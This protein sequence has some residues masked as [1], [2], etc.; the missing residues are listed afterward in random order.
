MHY[1]D[2]TTIDGPI[3]LHQVGNKLNNDRLVLSE[4]PLE[5]SNNLLKDLETY[6]L[7]HFKQMEYYCFTHDISL[8]SNEVYN[9]VT[10]I[11]EDSNLMAENSKYLA[12]TLYSASDHPNIKGGE[13]YV[14]KFKNC[15]VD[16]QMVDAVGLFKSE[17]KDLFFKILNKEGHFELINDRGVN[18]NKLDKGC[19]VFNICKESGY[20][21]SIV[22]NTNRGDA[23][24]WVQDFLQL[25]R[26]NDSYTQT[27]N[28]VHL[29]KEYISKLP[30]DIDKA[31][32]AAMMNRVI[33]RLNDE[34]VDVKEFAVAAFGSELAETS[35]DS[36]MNQYIEDHNVS[37]SESFQSC[38]KS[39]KSSALR[40]ITSIRLDS[41]FVINI[42][43]GEEMIVKEF[44]AERGMMYYKLYY[45]EE[46]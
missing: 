33:D 36:F 9:Y 34:V 19:I 1:F 42:K 16:G 41:N 15:L 27:Q 37:F 22:D 3:Y 13:F 2:S 28:L 26:I 8:S 5:I 39:I 43:G 23:K 6:F 31:D 21:V 11:F 35:F 20:V 14:V 17:N 25:K 46:R 40:K 10:A 12:I 45:K 7:S 24:Y 4:K 18:V 44:D 32:K 29:C 38:A 30:C